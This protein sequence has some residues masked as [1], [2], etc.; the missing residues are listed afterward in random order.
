MRYWISMPRLRRWR[1]SGQR[2]PVAVNLSPA[3][4][5]DSRLP[6]D[7]QALVERHQTEPAD[8]E[9]EIT[10]DTLM[11]DPNRALAVI[12]RISEMGVSFSLDDFGTGY[13]CLAQL[14]HLPVRS[15]KIDQSFI[16]NMAD[17]AEDA[18]IV[19]SAIELGHSL[20]L[21]VVAE[22]IESP[23]HL[24]QLEDYGCD[25]AQGF[26]LGRPLPAEQI[27]GWL[28][29]LTESSAVPARAETSAHALRSFEPAGR[30]AVPKLR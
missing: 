9:L 4:L 26:H 25:V 5:L 13:S 3:S 30:R 29:S 15:L 1:E 17:S 14:K 18:N 16:M 19:R 11:Q 22:G 24:R 8:L 10:E 20:N 12:A 21:T 2:I 28:R 7:V 27:P 6:D 23:E